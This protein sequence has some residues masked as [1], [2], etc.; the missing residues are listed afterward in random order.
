MIVRAAD[1]DLK[2]AE[3]LQT[4]L[5]E[6]REAQVE[7]LAEIAEIVGADVERCGVGGNESWKRGYL[8][9]TG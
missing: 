6:S 5:A 2:A 9:G 1:M 7:F 8:A 4:S 3:R